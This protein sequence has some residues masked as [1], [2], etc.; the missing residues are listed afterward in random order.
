MILFSALPFI[1]T[2][3]LVQWLVWPPS[4]RLI[5]VRFPDGEQEL[6][7]WLFFWLFLFFAFVFAFSSASRRRVQTPPL[8]RHVS[9]TDDSSR[10]TCRVDESSHGYAASVSHGVG[11]TFFSTLCIPL[12]RWS[13]HR[14][15]LGSIVASILACHARDPGSIPGRGVKFLF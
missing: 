2:S 3:P 10:L 4:K 13:L 5:R 12:F 8:Q 1:R 7:F 6:F 14:I 9:Q 11:R 15:I